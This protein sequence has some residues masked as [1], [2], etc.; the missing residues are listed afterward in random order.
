MKRGRW[1]EEGEEEGDEEQREEEQGRG[2]KRI[3]SWKGRGRGGAGGRGGGGG[4]T[5]AVGGD[6]RGLLEVH[7]IRQGREVRTLLLQHAERDTHTHT[8]TSSGIA[9]GGLNFRLI[10]S[11]PSKLLDSTI[12]AIVVRDHET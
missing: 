6:A 10:V 3:M 2:R 5:G 9:D 12:F 7:L 1:K 11:S 4:V 8:H